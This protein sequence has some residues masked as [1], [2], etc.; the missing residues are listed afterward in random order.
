MA[1]LIHISVLFLY[2]ST[3]LLLVISFIFIKLEKAI[4]S[5]LILAVSLGAIFLSNTYILPY[6]H[7]RNF[8]FYK[9]EPVILQG[10]VINSPC[11]ISNFSSFILSVQKLIWAERVYRVCGKVMVKVFR[12]EDISYADCL[13]LEGRLYR[14]YR[15]KNKNLSYCNYLEN[16]GI[17]SILTVSKNKRIRRLKGKNGVSYLRYLTYR[18]RSKLSD[19]LFRNLKSTRAGVLSAMVLGER[20]RI[21]SQLRRLFIQ[22]GTM[23]ILAISGLH[24]GIIAFMLDILFRFIGLNRGIRYS[25]IIFLLL[26]YCFLVGIRPSVVRAAIMADI[27]LIGSLLKREI[28]ISNS[29]AL[30]GMIILMVNPRQLFD[31]G[32]QLSFISVISIIYLSPIINRLLNALM[33][34]HRRVPRVFTNILH[35]G[36]NA[37]SISVGAWLGT[38]FLIAYYFRIVS[39]VGIL[40]NIVVIPYLSLVIA[41]GFS[42]LVIGLTFPFLSS[43]FALPAELALVFLIQIIRLFSRFPGAYFYL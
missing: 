35:F 1:K 41:S 11:K 42:L 18:V 37:L 5:F 14:P 33:I 7:I 34:T 25:I 32:F 10:V 29:I 38:S 8:T 43:I 22:T 2:A 19:I 36:I 21:P 27:L 39:P 12:A 13:I 31:V 26:F 24:V 20:G 15:I 6:P 4:Y 40:T 3:W 9:S 23:H 28:R 16:Q 17:Y 30:S